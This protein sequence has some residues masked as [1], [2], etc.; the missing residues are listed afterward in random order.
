[1][2]DL[3]I[4]QLP[5]AAALTGTELVEL[6]QSGG[7]V[8]TTAADLQ[9]VR[10]L[11]L[12]DF[13]SAALSADQT[14]E[15]IRTPVSLASMQNADLVRLEAGIGVILGGGTDGTGTLTVD[16]FLGGTPVSIS[17][18]GLLSGQTYT[19]RYSILS[20]LD[21]QGI[22]CTLEL[23]GASS[24]LPTVVAQTVETNTIIEDSI[25]GADMVFTARVQTPGTSGGTICVLNGGSLIRHRL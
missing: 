17:L 5:A 14:V 25:D 9:S 10:L 23:I 19:F 1:M 4:S 22:Q 2:A 11:A 6:V 24:T 13:F 21:P 12:F 15:I 7:N 8:Q 18:T 16:N 3:K 20:R